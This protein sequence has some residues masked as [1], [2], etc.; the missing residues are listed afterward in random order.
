MASGLGFAMRLGL[1]VLGALIAA[2]VSSSIASAAD[3]PTKAPVAIPGIAPAYSWS[4]FYVGGVAGY[5][6]L[7]ARHCDAS[8]SDFC[9]PITNPHGWN[10]GLTLGYN[11]QWARWVLGI[12]GD[13]SWADM[14][15]SSPSTAFFGCGGQ[16]S[17]SIDSFETLRARAGWAFDRALIY[18]TAG[19]GWTQLTAKL[20][21]TSAYDTTTKTSFVGGTGFEFALWQNWSAKAEYLYFTKLG[22]FAYDTMGACGSPGCFVRAKGMNE[23]RVGLNYRFG[24]LF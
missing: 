23:F 5:G 20:G 10:A 9:D 15:A 11:L 22:D 6:S 19:A 16:C 7:R 17:T 1:V 8:P 12:E 14:K 13:V 18:V 3:L 24:P 2:V 21:P 4:G